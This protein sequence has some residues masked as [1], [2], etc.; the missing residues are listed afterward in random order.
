MRKTG[1]ISSGS[2]HN[3]Y[4]RKP[5]AHGILR[6]TVMDNNMFADFMI[7]QTLAIALEDRTLPDE[8]QLFFS[9][10]C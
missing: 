8:Y 3:V 4:R 1:I 6:I 9:L 5:Y 2:L 7:Q 10:A